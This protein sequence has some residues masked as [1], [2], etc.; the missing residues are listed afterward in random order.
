[1]K[2]LLV[3][4]FTYLS[5]VAVLAQEV[6]PDLATVAANANRAARQAIR[7]LTATIRVESTVPGQQVL[8]VGSYIRSGNDARMRLGKEDHP[9]RGD[10]LTRQG[11]TRSVTRSASRTR[12]DFKITAGRTSATRL[13]TFGDLWHELLLDQTGPN[14]SHISYEEAMASGQVGKAKWVGS[15]GSNFVAVPVTVRDDRGADFVATYWHDPAHNYLVS[16]R[17]IVYIGDSEI[18]KAGGMALSEIT[19]WAEPAPGIFVPVKCVRTVTD[20]DEKIVDRQVATLTKVTVNKPIPASSM[21]LPA[22]PDGTEY[23]DEIAGTSGPVNSSWQPT[24]PRTPLIVVVAP[25]RL[26]VSEMG[27]QSTSEPASSG[28]WLAMASGVLVLVAASVI[29]YRKMRPGDSQ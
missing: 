23:R 15:G 16:R 29:A 27:G 3:G 8:T 28:T 14:G 24:G 17:E 13:R 12:D 1:M 20:Q 25:P 4:C 9:G 7:T 18:A 22:I 19:E 26:P 21:A 2:Y 6:E 11:E 10:L 5:G